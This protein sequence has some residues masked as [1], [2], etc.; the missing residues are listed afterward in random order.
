[1][2]IFVEGMGG[3]YRRPQEGVG[4][5]VEGMGGFYRRGALLRGWED[6]TEEGVGK[7]E[8]FLEA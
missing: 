7:I 5:F 2:G 8:R 1:M 3:F 6:F 4:I